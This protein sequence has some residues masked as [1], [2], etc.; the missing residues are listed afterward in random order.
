MLCCPWLRVVLGAAAGAEAPSGPRSSKSLH[1]PRVEVE[2]QV[3]P[4]GAG[5]KIFNSCSNPGRQAVRPGS[6]G[7]WRRARGE[8]KSLCRER[9]LGVAAD[10]SR[11]RVEVGSWGSQAQAGYTT[12]GYSEMTGSPVVSQGQYSMYKRGRR[13][14][15]AELARVR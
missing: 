5:R 2:L 3:M 1:G 10:S 7:C 9:C 14:Q 6:R 11:R 4:G 8:R 13:I 15:L 12:T